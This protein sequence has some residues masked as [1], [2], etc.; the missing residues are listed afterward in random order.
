[1]LSVM[2]NANRG[3]WLLSSQPKTV[4]IKNEKDAS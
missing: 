3:S 4:V 2:I 1:M